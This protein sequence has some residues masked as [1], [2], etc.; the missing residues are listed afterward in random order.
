MLYLHP[1]ILKM[2]TTADIRNGLCIKYNEKICQIV[3]FQHVKPGKGPAFVRTKMR[4]IETGKMI[5]NTFSAG[6]KIEVI[7]VENREYQFLFQEGTDFV[8]MNSE[9]FVKENEIFVYSNNEKITLLNELEVVDG[10]I[11]ANRYYEDKIYVIEEETGRIIAFLDFSDLRKQLR[12]SEKAE[13]LNGIAYYRKKNRFLI[14]G[15]LWSDFF[16]V[17][18]LKPN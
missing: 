12:N 15:K 8:F 16:E 4:V 18:I 2:A 5:D 3:E 11:W 7:R 1:K 9:N 13:V 17:E 14:T 6:H 10:H